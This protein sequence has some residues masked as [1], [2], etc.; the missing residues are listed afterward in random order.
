MSSTKAIAANRHRPIMIGSFVLLALMIAGGGT[1]A[2]LHGYKP[3]TAMPGFSLPSPVSIGNNW[4]SPDAAT[5]AETPSGPN[6]GLSAE[7]LAD[8][9]AHLYLP[10]LP[11]PVKKAMPA[12]RTV[13]AEAAT[14]AAPSV[15]P[16]PKS[17]SLVSDSTQEALQTMEAF[18]MAM[19]S[20]GGPDLAA[21]HYKDN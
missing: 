20:V 9:R 11:S 12:K 7:R 13:T 18:K 19:K 21:R 5:R 8:I 6:P 10:S 17:A 2:T 14:G 16:Q 3:Q 4:Q 15:S 1:V